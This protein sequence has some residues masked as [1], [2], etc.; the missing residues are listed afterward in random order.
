MRKPCTVLAIADS[1]QS[2]QN[3]CTNPNFWA[4]HQGIN[5]GISMVNAKNYKETSGNDR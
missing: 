2:F 3:K 5:C 4:S 1:P